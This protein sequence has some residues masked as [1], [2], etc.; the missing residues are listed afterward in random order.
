MHREHLLAADPL[1]DHVDGHAAQGEQVRQELP[2]VDF[3]RARRDLVGDLPPHRT[4]RP[5]PRGDVMV[6][7]FRHHTIEIEENGFQ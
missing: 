1:V 5:L 3:R 7:G 4:E 2:V 6:L